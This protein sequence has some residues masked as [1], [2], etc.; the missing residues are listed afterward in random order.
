M[1]TTQLRD[2]LARYEVQFQESG[3]THSEMDDLEK[4]KLY[5]RSLANWN[6]AAQVFDRR[7]QTVIFSVAA[8]RASQGSEATGSLG[9]CSTVVEDST[10]SHSRRDFEFPPLANE[11]SHRDHLDATG[12]SRGAPGATC[13]VCCDLRDGG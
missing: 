7:G 3:K 5:A 12:A 11:S 9:R 10:T 1:R 6:H 8:Y 13:G 2:S 4:A